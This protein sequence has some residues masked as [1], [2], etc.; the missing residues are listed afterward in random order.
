VPLVRTLRDKSERQER[1]PKRVQAGNNRRRRDDPVTVVESAD[2]AQAEELGL[3]Q[4][5]FIAVKDDHLVVVEIKAARDQLRRTQEEINENEDER[6]RLLRQRRELVA[7]LRAR[8]VLKSAMQRDL[9]L[10]YMVVTQDLQ[11]AARE[12][13]Q[14]DCD[15]KDAHRPSTTPEQTTTKSR[16]RNRQPK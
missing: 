8:G 14:C 9:G 15:L 12:R 3:K 11:A 6:L 5:D 10:S 16:S 4:A 1:D 2:R 13:D 7:K